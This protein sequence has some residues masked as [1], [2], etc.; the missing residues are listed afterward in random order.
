[1]KITSF[2]DTFQFLLGLLNTNQHLP[3][4]ISVTNVHIFINISNNVLASS[5]LSFL[6]GFFSM[7]ST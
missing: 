3:A 1:M 4:L 2:T 7:S 5:G 6:C